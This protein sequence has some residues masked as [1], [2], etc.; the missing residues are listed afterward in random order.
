MATRSDDHIIVASLRRTADALM[1]GSFDP[2]ETPVHHE[3]AARH[4][5]L[6]DRIEWEQA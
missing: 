4:R 6:A 2:A 3:N 5:A 1:V